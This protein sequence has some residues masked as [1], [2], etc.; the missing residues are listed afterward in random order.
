[1]AIENPFEQLSLDTLRQR[2]SMKWRAFGADVL[3]L[4]VAEMDVPLAEPVVRAIT[5]AAASGDTG[6][7]VGRPYAE[8]LSDFA[9]WRW[10]WTGLEVSRTALVP[11]VMQ[12][13][14]ELLRLVTDPGSAVV[15]N[16]PVYPPFYSFV[17]HM[18]RTIV[19]APLTTD[20]RIDFATL[21]TAFETAA[22]TGPAAFLLCNPHNPT[23]TAHTRDELEQVAELS[24]RFGVRVV[25]DEIHAPLVLPGAT[26][27]PYLNVSGSASGFSLMSAS[28]A[29]NLPGLKAAIA[30][31]GEAAADDLAQMPEEV[32]HGPSHLGVLA[33]TAALRHGGEW[34]D[35]ALTGLDHNRQL[36]GQLL[37]KHLPSVSWTPPE[38]TYLAWLD[39]GA[40]GFDATTTDDARGNVAAAAGPAATFLERGKVALSSGPAFGTGGAAHAR[41][42]FATTPTILAEAVQRMGEVAHA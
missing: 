42:N 11:D 31:A 14:V 24:H 6:Y 29:W 41:L 3:P 36:L 37:R 18:G 21:H 26:F 40:L 23:G 20:G 38:A 22:R 12:G 28:K 35:A 33:H 30:I 16:C 15:V 8:A 25:A 2:S 19:E 32:S 10:S 13:A 39:C 34:L 17:E 7:P 27:T 5:D 1:M 4:W 9:A